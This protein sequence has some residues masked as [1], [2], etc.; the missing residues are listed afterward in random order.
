MVSVQY[1][2]SEQAGPAWAVWNGVV[3]PSVVLPLLSAEGGLSVVQDLELARDSLIDGAVFGVAA[4]AGDFPATRIDTVA[5]VRLATEGSGGTAV[6][7]VDFGRLVTVAGVSVGGIDDLVERWNGTEFVPVAGATPGALGEVATERLKLY[8]TEATAASIGAGSVVLPAVPT[9]LELV[10]AGT[11]VWFERQGGDPASLDGAPTG[12]V[13][14][15]VDRTDALREAFRRAAATATADLV[16]VRCELRAATP[17]V[18]QLT[19]AVRR[20]RVHAVVFP[21]GPSRTLEIAAEGAVTLTLPL[22]PTSGAWEVEAVELVARG[23][24]PKIRALPS[25]GPEPATDAVLRLVPGRALLGRLPARLLER[26][27]QLHAVRLLVAGGEAGG[28]LGG[29][30]L[31]GTGDD[32]GEPTEAVP[33]GEL[34]PVRVAPGTAAEW[35]TL[36]LAEPTEPPVALWL[37]L[38][39]ASGSLAWQLTAATADDLDAPGAPLRRRLPGGGVRPLTT[40]QALSERLGML[41]LVGVPDPNRPVEALELGVGA[42]GQRA[43]FTPTGDGVAVQLGRTPAATPTTAPQG[44]MLALTGAAAAPGSYTFEQLTVVYQEPPS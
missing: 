29:I 44:Q 41:R 30:L 10:V 42:D 9:G 34:L 26:F 14:Y 39:A 3:Y 18:L 12:D 24:I 25:T 4:S 6:A 19:T 28:E 21:D 35:V 13:T 2:F 22:P 23:R 33:G 32:P 11:T 7:I 40:V 5:E 20:R 17:G 1:Q 31:G 8:P 37:E 15:V 38:Q 16:T 36:E 43:P 27:A